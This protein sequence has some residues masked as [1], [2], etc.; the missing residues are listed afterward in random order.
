MGKNSVSWWEKDNYCLIALT[1]DGMTH[2][3][4][5]HTY[6]DLDYYATF[7]EFSPNIYSAR[8]MKFIGKKWV[9]LFRIG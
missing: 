5:Y 1:K 6:E 8:G 2:R 3:H 9:C 7:Y 4:Y